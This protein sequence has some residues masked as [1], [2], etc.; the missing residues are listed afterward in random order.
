MEDGDAPIESDGRETGASLVRL[1]AFSD[2]VFAIAMTLLV[3]N[4]HVPDL[5]GGNRDERLWEVFR[6]QI[7]ELWSYVLSFAVVGRYWLVHHRMFQMVRAADTHLLV[8]NLFL[9]GCVALIPWP[10][11]ILGL[12]GDTTAG[13]V[14][15][16][17]ALTLTGLGN[18]LVAHHIDAAGL[19]VD[20]V[21]DAYR[22]HTRLRSITLPV[23]F[24]LSIPLAFLDPTL[25]MVS[26]AI[27]APALGIY[28]RRKYG[29]INRP[30]VTDDV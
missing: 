29:K 25:A 12:Y 11:E 20:G 18:F 14:V 8:V 30:F 26:W 24:G 1:I 10:T 17:S 27:S 16:S 21:S 5:V 3:L 2:G 23:V 9:L 15:Y 7:P 4:L 28:G 6:E 13:V 19:W 22:A